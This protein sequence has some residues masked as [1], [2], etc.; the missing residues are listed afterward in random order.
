MN[1][2]PTT[3]SHYEIL[4]ASPKADSETIERL[5]RHLAKRYHPDVAESGDV[6][7]FSRIVE[8]Y[9]VLRCPQKRAKYDAAIANETN[10]VIGLERE[11][12]ALNDDATDRHHLLS[13]L[14]A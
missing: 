13:L 11:V 3:S 6:Q 5:F 4:E 2:H 10:A 12:E 7:R 9:E 1:N 8:A 14:Y